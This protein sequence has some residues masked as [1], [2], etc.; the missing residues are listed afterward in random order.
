MTTFLKALLAGLGALLAL[1]TA[2]A[3]PA[4][5]KEV[6]VAYSNIVPESLILKQQGWL[7]KALEPQGIKVKWVESLGSNK[8][9]EFLRGKNIDIGLSSLAS[10]FLAR[11]NGTPI[12]YVYWTSRNPT[13]SPI[14]VLDGSP[15]KSIAD[16]KGKKIAATP[17]TGP[18]ISLIA[19]LKK[20]G[21]SPKDVS[22][23]A[24]QH[25]DGRVALAAKRVDAWAGLDP[26][27]AIAELQNHAH[28]LFADS[29]LAGGG[30]VDVRDEFLAEHPDIVHTVLNGLNQ[31]RVYEHAHP[32]EAAQLFARA[33]KID[34]PVAK[35]VLQRNWTAHPELQP[36][37]AI[38]LTTWGNLY[39]QIGD[40][41]A[42]TNVPAI[43]NAVL[44]ASVFTV[45]T[46]P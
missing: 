28:V 26:D 46:Q 29:T 24:L 18:Y 35:R 4:P 42:D 43:V 36:H 39:K 40:I 17:G 1:N 8:A 32:D 7:E 12:K 23:V 44:D 33:V 10:A 25:P 3:A 22:I 9:I 11:A 19:A 13:G 14:L 34:L 20:Y 27:W 38:D 16:L 30:G 41:P 21:L 37:D 45:P 6:A 5:L 2:N 31:A 15:Y